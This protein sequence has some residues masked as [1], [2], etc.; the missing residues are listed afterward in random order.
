[1]VV[2]LQILGTV[3]L[4][5]YLALM[6]FA[7]IM[8]DKMIFPA[9]PVGY[10]RSANL[11]MLTLPDGSEIAATTRE[12]PVPQQWLIYCHGNGEDLGSVAP[13]LTDFVRRG[14]S[15][16]AI[17]YPGYG[18][19]QGSASEKG[20]YQ[21][22]DAAYLYLTTLRGVSPAA[23]IPYGRSVGSGPATYLAETQPVGGL[24]LESAFTST[25]RVMLPVNPLPWDKF[26]NLKRASH[27]ACPVLI[28]HGKRDEVIPFA[29]G[30]KL[31]AV[32]PGP[33]QHLWSEVARHN[34]LAEVAGKAYW[35]ALEK[36]RQTVL[37]QNKNVR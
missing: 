19:S 32:F 31:K 16:I 27:I 2:I 30:E 24:I 25:F 18:H 26:D 29:H 9:P 4:L 11:I 13:M 17:D 7:L 12:Q 35:E 5:S 20:C 33:K 1:M 15:V 28:M 10:P 21:A 34:D 8:A 3:I 14:W 6:G 37:E 23:I 22:I 36:F